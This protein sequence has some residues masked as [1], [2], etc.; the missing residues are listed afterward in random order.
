VCG[1]R[2]SSIVGRCGVMGN[3]MSALCLIGGDS[4]GRD[5]VKCVVC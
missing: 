5:R 2:G 3:V 1:I 4:V